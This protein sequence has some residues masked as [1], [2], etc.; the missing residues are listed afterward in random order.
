MRRRNG[1]AARI[2]AAAMSIGTV[3]HASWAAAAVV[4]TF[5]VTPGEITAGGS[6]TLNLKLDLLADS[7]YRDAQFTGGS[8]TLFSGDGTSIS[9]DIGSGG[10]LRDFSHSFSYADPGTYAASFLVN[11]TY[12]QLYDAYVYL[13]TIS[14]VVA[15]GHNAC[16]WWCPQKV[17]TGHKPAYGWKTYSDFSKSKLKGKA[18]VEVSAPVVTPIPA[19][20]PLFASGLGAMGLVAWRNRRKA[21]ADA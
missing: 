16:G 7:G 13:Y 2:L 20:L 10:V 4:P 3:L 6:S 11:A 14:Y 8:A 1:V 5:T 9:F 21:R 12:T 18:Y 15:I 19:A 17:K